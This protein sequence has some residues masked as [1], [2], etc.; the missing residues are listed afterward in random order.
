MYGI[1]DVQKR[2]LNTYKSADTLKK[3]ARL[4]VI[5]KLEEEGRILDND[6]VTKHLN[7]WAETFTEIENEQHTA[8]SVI[9]LVADNYVYT[10]THHYNNK[11][12]ITSDEKLELCSEIEKLL[13]EF[14]KQ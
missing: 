7:D 4:V 9:P 12:P 11:T 10:N 13:T 2:V 1:L 5:I 14:L 6:G 8:K 3:F